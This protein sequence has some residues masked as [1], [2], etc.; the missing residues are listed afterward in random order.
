MSTQVIKKKE[1]HMKLR[2][3]LED[4]GVKAPTF[5]RQ[6]NVNP[7]TIYSIMRGESDCML[8]IA[9]K[10]ER[11]TKG[12]VKCQDIL[13]SKF[14]EALERK[15]SQDDSNEDK[16]KQCGKDKCIGDESEV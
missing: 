16:K 10:I 2:E 6:I 7:V 1:K 14:W 12:K 5:A 11:K 9:L 13:D 8:S 15:E 3:Y 4:L